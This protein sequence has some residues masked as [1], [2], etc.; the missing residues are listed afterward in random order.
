MRLVLHKIEV[1]LQ[2]LIKNLQF[3]GDSVSPGLPPGSSPECIRAS[4]I[5]MKINDLKNLVVLVL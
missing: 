3:L 4:E 2:S 5:S 1:L